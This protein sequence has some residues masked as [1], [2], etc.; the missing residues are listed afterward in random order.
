MS[1]AV[2]YLPACAPPSVTSRAMSLARQHHDDEAIALL[3]RD[4]A[5]RPDDLDARRLLIR[6]LGSTGHL[7]LART[8]V[9]ELTRRLPPN[10]PTPSVELGHAL[11]LAH[12]YEDAL[13]QYDKAAEIAPANPLGP[14]EGGMRAARW[15]E[16]AIARPRLEEAVKRGAHDAELFHVLGL[17]RLHDGELDAASEAYEKG[18]QQDPKAI[19]N[20]LG[21]ASV[22]VVKG[23]AALALRRYDAI[24]A[25]RPSYA[26]ASLGRAWALGKLHQMDAA[27]QELDHALELG[28]SPATVAKLRAR[29]PHLDDPAPPRPPEE[30]EPDS[31]DRP[32]FRDDV[33]SPP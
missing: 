26:P 23:D 11:E 25:R 30:P 33:P 13:A 16:S 15:G 10:D 3:R 29:L 9:D 1:A 14:R 8:E 31:P 19:E 4:L 21:L 18:L 2:S 6:L 22:A 28:A 24:L 5:K 7:D 27:T 32:D 17:V 20:L 12:K